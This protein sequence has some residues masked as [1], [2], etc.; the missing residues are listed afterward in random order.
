MKIA[1]RPK[2][3]L[4]RFGADQRGNVA[5]MTGLL[6]I[7]LVGAI[8]V[9]IDYTRL[10]S[11]RLKMDSAAT[12]ASLAAVDTARALL[13]SNPNISAV[14]LQAAA[15]ARAEQVF[16]GRAPPDTFGVVAVLR[17]GDTMSAKVDFTGNLATTF[18]GVLSIPS[19]TA[20]GA[21][22]S[23]GQIAPPPNASNPDILV[24]EN[25]NVSGVQAVSYHGGTYRYGIY[26]DF[27]NWK[28]NKGGIEIGLAGGYGPPPPNGATHVAELDAFENNYIARKI[29]LTPGSYELRYWYLDRIVDAAYAPA[30]VCGSSTAD[31]SWANSVVDSKWGAGLKQT[32]AISVYLDLANT[33]NPPAE[34]LP[35]THTQ[36]DT[37]VLAGGKWIERSVKITTFAP[38]FHWLAFQAE[39]ESDAAGGVLSGIRF[40]KNTCAGT[41]Q[42][43]FPWTANQELFRDDF[44][45]ITIPLVNTTLA[46]SPLPS[47]SYVWWTNGTLDR[48]GSNTGWQNLPT[49]WATAPFNQMDFINAIA[50][51][52]GGISVEVDA[53][54]GNRTMSRRFI[55]TPGYYRIEWAYAS[56]MT[57]ADM[58]L[59]IVCGSSANATT[60]LAGTGSA[61]RS[62][63]LLTGII[64]TTTLYTRPRNTNT[65]SVY[66]DSNRLISHPTHGPEFYAP[67]TYKNP[68]GGAATLPQLPQ[69][70][71]DTCGYSYNWQQRSVNVKI[72]KT[73]FYWLTFRGEGA[74]DSEGGQLANFRMYAVGGLSGSAPANVVSIPFAGVQPGGINIKP[75]F[76]FVGN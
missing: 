15:K 62:P 16:A 6:A 9:G 31:V 17:L 37:C 45:N 18:M 44:T 26:K 55:L 52:S 24:D 58:G 19:M 35:N 38:G 25:F 14:E 30:H 73:D 68:D 74:S 34:F 27:N 13:L 57:F 48:S 75:Q 23:T 47:G 63:L 32:N 76:Q 5:L 71:I 29:Y 43:N 49:G 2:S 1:L 41:P 22:K 56:R 60:K 51:P 64:N 7:P 42:E 4:A 8:G 67:S 28:T 70:M 66:L 3:L 54:S 69:Q 50:G 11:H 33:D 12:A 72:S 21:S 61:T 59:E 10:V 46:T 53:T 39:G 36:I 20:S 40:C 65:V